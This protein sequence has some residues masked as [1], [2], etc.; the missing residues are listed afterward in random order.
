MTC[1]QVSDGFGNKH[2]VLIYH[3][4]LQRKSNFGVGM[5]GGLLDNAQV[6]NHKNYRVLDK[7]IHP[8]YTPL[9]DPVTCYSR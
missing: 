9:N 6:S 5:G 8:R 3:I 4:K 1:I 2:G 7:D